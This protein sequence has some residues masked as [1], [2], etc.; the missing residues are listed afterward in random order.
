MLAVFAES[1]PKEVAYSI[2][3]KRLFSEPPNIQERPNELFIHVLINIY[4]LLKMC[5]MNDNHPYIDTAYILII[6][7]QT[8]KKTRMIFV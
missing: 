5:Q 1:A 8:A 6:L 4:V 2:S 3:H 7:V